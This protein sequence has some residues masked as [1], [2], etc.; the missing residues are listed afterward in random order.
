MWLRDSKDLKDP[1]FLNTGMWEEPATAEQKRAEAN[2]NNF[3]TLMNNQQGVVNK[4][5]KILPAQVGNGNPRCKI[6]GCPALLSHVNG[7]YQAEGK[8]DSGKYDGARFN[9]QSYW[10]KMEDQSLC[11]VEPKASLTQ[12]T[13]AGARVKKGSEGKIDLKQPVMYC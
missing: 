1:S 13:M 4:A 6:S 12:Y 5:I 11:P 9:G 8:F 7:V 2:N 10:F 3:R